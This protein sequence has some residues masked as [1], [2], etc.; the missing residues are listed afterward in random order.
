MRSWQPDDEGTLLL[1]SALSGSPAASDAWAAWSAVHTISGL[2]LGALRLL[3]LVDHNLQRN[4]Q[5]EG[6]GVAAGTVLVDMWCETQLL[7]HEAAVLLG[8]L[9]DAGIDTIV[10]KG[11]ALAIL[12]YPDP[13]LRPM[14]DVDVLVRARDATR[15]IDVLRDAGWSSNGSS[16]DGLMRFQHA[17]PFSNGQG[18]SVDL[19]W[20]V[21]WQRRDSAEGDEAF[22]D[23]SIPATFND[24]ETRA[25]AAE[26]RLLHVC[27][28]GLAWSPMLPIRWV[29][30]AAMIIRRQGTDLDWERLIEHA[31]SRRLALPLFDALVYLRT[32]FA[33][34]VPD[35]VIEGLRDA[36]TRRSTRLAHRIRT[37]REGTY[38]SHLHG[39]WIGSTSDR[40]A[41]AHLGADQERIR[42]VLERLR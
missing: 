6:I 13:L 12:D 37:G 36:P 7:F 27:V 5:T 19:H 15:A 22:W 11:A 10:L 14:T 41:P 20:R 8:T 29:A 33:L 21:L 39:W 31:H 40:S 3:P 1:V 35:R 25:L 16:V 17:A 2:N 23:R 42:A 38:L 34:P 4:G 32:A 24:V 28:H 30:D 26:D 9:E 18:G